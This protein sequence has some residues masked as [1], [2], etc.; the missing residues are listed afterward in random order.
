MK[1]PRNN[2]VNNKQLQEEMRKYRI[3][4]EESINNNT[5]IPQASKYIGECI[6]NI[7]NRYAKKPNFFGYTNLWK[8]EM[9]SDGI[10][11]CIK[12]GLKNY[13][14]E[15]Y[16]NPLAYFTKI[17]HQSFIKRI[18]SEK[19]EQIKKFKSK[20]NQDLQLQLENQ[21]YIPIDDEVSDQ[22]IKNYEEKINNKK[23]KNALKGIDKFIE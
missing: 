3:E 8:E 10:E 18:D 14:P 23:L 21:N 19:K 20:I 9:I 22:L 12:Y 6:Y 2:Y 4:L 17:I 7:A 15:K 5:Q 1:K 16:N 11:N 13:N